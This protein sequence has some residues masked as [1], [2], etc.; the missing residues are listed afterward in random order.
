M[1]VEGMQRLGFRIAALRRVHP[2]R[3]WHPGD[4][5]DFQRKLRGLPSPEGLQ[6]GT[7]VQ[8]RQWLPVVVALEDLIRRNDPRNPNRIIREM[9]RGRYPY[10]G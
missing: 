8:Y 10:L 5:L 9:M 1:Q 4:E 7:E 6:A 3:G 2:D